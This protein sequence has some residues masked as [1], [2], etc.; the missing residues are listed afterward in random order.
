VC[1][2]GK[3]VNTRSGPKGVCV[4][5]KGVNTR[6]GPKS[7]CVCVCVERGV[8]SELTEKWEDSRTY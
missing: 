4:Y 6:S 8:F 5:G 7:V 3:G 2:C 1:V